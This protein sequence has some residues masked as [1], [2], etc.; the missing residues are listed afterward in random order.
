MNNRNIITRFRAV[1]LAS[2]VLV[3]VAPGLASAQTATDTS[4]HATPKTSS[5]AT[6]PTPALETV[7]VTAEKRESLAQHTA[8]AISVID[9]TVL[10]NQKVKQLTDLNNVLSDTQIVPVL[11]STQ[12]SI[13][14]IGS[15][16]VDQRADPA[17]ATSING[18]YYDRALP[19]GFGFLDVARVEVLKGP[20][21]TLYGRNAAAGAINIVTNQPTNEFGGSIQ[22]TGGNLGENDIIAIVNLPV[23]D[24]LALRVAYDRDRRDGYLGGYYNDI[25][26]D[27]GRVSARWTPTNKLTIYVEG[28][29]IKLGGHGA[30]VSPWPCAGS[31]PWSLYVPKTCALLGPGGDI[32]KGGTNGS[33]V[34]SAQVH[35]DY[36]FGPVVLTSISG[37]VGTHNRNFL[38]NGSLFNQSINSDSND[39]SEELRLAGI[40]DASHAG[41][42]EWQV[43]TY[44]FRSTG[45]YAFNQQA[46]PAGNPLYLGSPIYAKLLTKLQTY[47]KIPQSSES[48]YAQATYGLSDRLRITGGLRYSHDSKGLTYSQFSYASTTA[49]TES[50]VAAGRASLSGDRWSYKAGLEYDLAPESLLYGNISTGY[51]AGGVNGGDPNAPLPPNVTPAVFQPETITAYEVGSKNRFLDDRLQINGDFYYYDFHN[52][53]YLYS[54]YVQGGGTVSD[55]QEQNAASMKDYGAELSGEFALTSDDRLT[56]SVAWAHA[57]FGALNYAALS[58][59]T[60]TTVVVAAG[61]RVPNDPD[62]SGLVGYEHTFRLDNGDFITFSA[63]SKLSSSYLLVVGS[64]DPFDTQKG[65]TRTD[66]SLAYHL[67]EDKYE[68]QLWVKNIENVPVNIYSEGARFHDYGIEPPRTYGVTLSTKF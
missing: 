30:E 49:T 67:A 35:I 29:Y 13:R 32:E 17:V 26:S 68:L 43:G 6:P 14:G 7:V 66:A 64:K 24:T 5:Q 44:L 18:L 19:V 59:V 45:N 47:S 36:D 20:Q 33:Y 34:D 23:D 60:P 61:S 53:Q 48:V 1:L 51:V 37:Y 42:L 46:Y 50:I 11:I 38:P 25:H 62:W 9:S 57:R 63:N 15:N 52:F 8:A 10:S 4:N 31:K 16:F 58:G 21:G 28:N 27:T 22:V 54:S 39:Y 40:D 41:G 2:S 56:A 65:F 3:A 12:V 55:L